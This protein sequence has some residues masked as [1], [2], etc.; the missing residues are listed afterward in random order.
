MICVP[1]NWDSVFYMLVASDAAALLLLT[2]IFTRWD[3]YQDDDLI[4]SPVQLSKVLNFK[5]FF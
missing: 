5:S 3:F 4:L 1:G 2:R